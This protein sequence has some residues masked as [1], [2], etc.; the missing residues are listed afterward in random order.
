MKKL[1]AVALLTL[2]AVIPAFGQTGPSVLSRVASKFVASN[3]F[4]L[5]AQVVSGNSSTGSV[6]IIVGPVQQSLQDGR[7][8]QMFQTGVLNPIIIDLGANNETVTPTAVSIGSC[9]SGTPTIQ[10][11]ATITGTFNNT[12]GNGSVVISGSSGFGEAYWDAALNGGG[13][14]VIDQAWTQL[15]G[16]DA[17]IRATPVHPKVAAEDDRFYAT[18]YWTPVGGLTTL[19]APATLTAVTALPSATPVGAYG[20]G[21]YFMCISY[22]DILGQEGPCSA[23]FSQA[24]LAT[25]SFIFSPPAASA[26]AIGYKIY[27]SLTSGTYQLAYEV[28][29]TSTIC[30]LTQLTAVPACAVANTAFNQSGATA[31]V[32][33]I[34][35]N[36]SPIDPQVTT[37]STTAVYTPNAGGR[38]VYTLTPGSHLGTPGLPV[39]FSPFTIGAAA[40]TV[41]PA[42]IGSVNI[43]PGFMNSVGRTIEICGYGTSTA[44]ASTIEN[45]QFQWDAFGQNTAGKG[46]LIGNLTTTT[47]FATTGHLGFCEDFQTTVTGA[48]ATA[49]SIINTGGYIVAAGVDLAATVAGGG[50]TLAAAVASLNLA[51]EAR[52]NIIYLHT[53]ATD[54]AGYILQG[55]TVKV[56]N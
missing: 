2:T 50:N 37:I 8:V 25:G 14:V 9:P 51:G 54:G 35:V 32:T 7:Q 18:Q 47:T 39:A 41:V 3:Y 42:V 13:L 19:A 16:T 1:L 48:G 55:I 22:V 43:P 12:H 52:I 44:T 28:P 21:T 45:I 27:I 17:M 4:A 5:R 36:T 38:T 34:T 23:T 6:S 11:C 15:G 49:G 56:L 53:T 40:A 29:L 26:G 31:T 30:T 20:T 24:G 46:V 10:N 33:A